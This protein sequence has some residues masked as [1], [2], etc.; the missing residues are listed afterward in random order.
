MNTVPTENFTQDVH[1]N[2]NNDLP[3]PPPLISFATQ[4]VRS[5]TNAAKQNSL[6]E[7]YSSLKL[8]IIGLQETNF[9]Q[10]SIRSFNRMFSSTYTGFFG[11]PSD[12]H[13]QKTG[14]GVGLL[15]RP[16]LANH[17]FHHET[18]HNRIIIVDL[19]FSNKQKLRII[20]CYLP[21]GNLTRRKPMPSRAGR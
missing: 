19:Q 18:K 17:I 1:L 6:I 10:S 4:N 7:F 20:N 21:P 5:F 9:S 11:L 3:S 2:T 13:S 8:D 12:S 15:V 16:Y 14:F